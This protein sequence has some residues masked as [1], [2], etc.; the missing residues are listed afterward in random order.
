M[1]NEAKQKLY[2]M[3]K[4][5]RLVEK[6]TRPYKLY[7]WDRMINI[8]SVLYKKGSTMEAELKIEMKVLNKEQA[9]VYVYSFEK[10]IFWGFFRLWFFLRFS[11]PNKLNLRPDR[12]EK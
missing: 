3:S 6:S 9:I 1:Q 2:T 5:D 11:P 10:K 4:F 12:P 8:K 7:K